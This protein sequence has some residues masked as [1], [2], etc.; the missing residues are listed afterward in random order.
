M[1][2]R[3]FFAD[4]PP[5][6]LDRTVLL[7]HTHSISMD[8]WLSS[9]TNNVF[10]P[11][12]SPADGSAVLLSPCEGASPVA[13]T[14]TASIACREEVPRAGVKDKKRR[15]CEACRHRR[16]KCQR[17]DARN[18]SCD[19]CV[20]M[21]IRQV[22]CTCLTRVAARWR[23]GSCKRYLATQLLRLRTRKPRHSLQL[24]IVHHASRQLTLFAPSTGVWNPSLNQEHRRK[25]RG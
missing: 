9:Y 17:L 8:S 2:D 18:A 13:S 5:F 15:A 24:G 11:V 25:A 20:K 12:C 3:D 10:S 14:S 21:D 4:I 6:L 19:S 16:I 7:K 1:P 22:E 23:H